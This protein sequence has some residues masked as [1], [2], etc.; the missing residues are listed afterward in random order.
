MKFP[1]NVPSGVIVHKGF[2]RNGVGCGGQPRYAR[3]EIVLTRQGNGKCANISFLAETFV[4]GE[5]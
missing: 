3:I 5:N 1:Q 4:C 2:L